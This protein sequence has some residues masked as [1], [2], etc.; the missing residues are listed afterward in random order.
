[1]WLLSP[2]IAWLVS[3]PLPQRKETVADADRAMLR[4]LACKTWGFFEAFV[5]DEDH[6]L[7]PD[8]Y[9]EGPVEAVAHRTSPTNVGLLLTS[10]LA[11]HDLGYLS[12]P[13]LIDRLER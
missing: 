2:V 1:L 7:P 12:L 6:W 13:E 9:Q 11:A 8:N 4:R 3:R 5:G 10:T